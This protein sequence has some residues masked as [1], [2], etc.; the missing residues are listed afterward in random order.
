MAELPITET[1]IGLDELLEYVHSVNLYDRAKTLK[2]C[3]E[4]EL[5]FVLQKVGEY[6][7]AGEITLKIKIGVGDRNQLNITGDVSSK[8]PKGYINQN[9]FYQDSRDGS[10]YLDDPNQLKMF[11]VERIR[12][13]EHQKGAVND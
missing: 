3:L 9:I 11:K 13:E 12:P 4:D 7:K 5:E 1:K 8:S 10:I 6:R 2:A